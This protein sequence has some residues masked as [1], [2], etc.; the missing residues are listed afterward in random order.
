MTVAVDSYTQ[1]KGEQK[2]VY[3]PVP[4]GYVPVA[5][6]FEWSLSATMIGLTSPQYNG[7]SWF[8]RIIGLEDGGKVGGTVHVLCVQKS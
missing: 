2:Y 7:T 8:V 3:L 1:T 4:S 6:Y 5:C